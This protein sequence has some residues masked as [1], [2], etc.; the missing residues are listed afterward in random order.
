[1]LIID[2]LALK[3]RITGDVIVDMLFIDTEGHDPIILAGAESQLERRLVRCLA[4]EYHEMGEWRSHQLEDVVRR[5]D[6]IGYD[7]F[8]Q[9]TDQLWPLSGA[10]WHPGY[11]FHAW[12]NVL[13]VLRGDIWRQ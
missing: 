10:C 7:C 11:E 1:M 12:S 13:C 5:L 8:L 4:F 9:G 6:S 3:I 2:D